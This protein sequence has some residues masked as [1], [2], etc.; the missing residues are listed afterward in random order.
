[1]HVYIYVCMYIRDSY[2]ITIKL[3]F[4]TSS[5]KIS[6]KIYDKSKLKSKKDLI[7]NYVSSEERYCVNSIFL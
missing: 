4:E 5:M 7:H 6:N 1:M 3:I 2:K